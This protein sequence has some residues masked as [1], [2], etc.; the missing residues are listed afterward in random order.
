M[1]EPNLRDIGPA[2][3]YDHGLLSEIGRNH[4][5]EILDLYRPLY[6][7]VRNKDAVWFGLNLIWP[8]QEGFYE[9]VSSSNHKKMEELIA[10]VKK[11]VD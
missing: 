1:K 9:T 4:R 7:K 5:T 8:G 11:I 2:I 3:A 6:E 10:M